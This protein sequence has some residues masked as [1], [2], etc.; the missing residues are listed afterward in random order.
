MSCPRR[1]GRA[2]VLALTLLFA[3]VATVFGEDARP[4]LDALPTERVVLETQAKG[5]HEYTAWRVDTPDTRARGLM[6]VPALTDD[7]AMIFVYDEPQRVSMWMKNTYLSLDMLF[8][9]ARGCIVHV[10]ERARPLSLAAI[11][12]GA[13]VVLV[14]EI[15]GGAAAVRGAKIGDR[16]RRPEAAWPADARGGC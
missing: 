8:V 9:D 1:A 10:A 7:Q 5:R 2:A 3:S 4:A 6:Y 13:P 16:I 15:K 14:V 12:S 11:E